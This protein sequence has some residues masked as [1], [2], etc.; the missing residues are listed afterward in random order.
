MAKEEE[1][2]KKKENA[3]RGWLL[4]VDLENPAELHEQRNNYPWR[5]RKKP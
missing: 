3:K 4:E 2:L 1:I 5:R